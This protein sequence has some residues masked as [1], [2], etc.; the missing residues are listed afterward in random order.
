[1]VCRPVAQLLWKPTC[2]L[3]L[4]MDDI[5]W[6]PQNAQLKV[7]ALLPN[8]VVIKFANG[9]AIISRHEI[10]PNHALGNMRKCSHCFQILQ[11]LP[12]S[13]HMSVRTNGQWILKSSPN[14]RR[15]R[16]GRGISLATARRWLHKEGFKYI[17]HKK[18]LYFDG[19]DRPDVVKYCQE[20]FLPAMKAYEPQLVHY[21][22][23]EV[24]Q[25][26]II[27]HDN[28]VERR[29]V[30]LAQDEMTAQANDIRSKTWVL[31]D[32]HHLRKKGVDILCSTVG[33]LDEG[34]QTEYGKNY[35]GYW[36]GELFI[37]Q[38]NLINY[39]TTVV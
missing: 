9:L 5:R 18:G 4:K 21:V 35:E 38:V 29:L 2:D 39:Y 17:H 28:Y 33:W 37:K 6:M 8:G 30:L 10:C 11:S 31:G 12:S 25:E 13:G 15:M 26:L 32:Q 36:T 22:V 23:G 19:H 16:V 24:D 27:P 7:V 34:S 1:M 14:S 20:H 3:S